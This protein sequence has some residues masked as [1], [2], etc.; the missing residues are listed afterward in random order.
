VS[1]LFWILVPLGIALGLAAGL[2]LRSE[3]ARIGL[4]VLGVVCEVLA[5]LTASG[6]FSP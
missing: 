2:P 1:T 6:V 5:I 3:A 4:I